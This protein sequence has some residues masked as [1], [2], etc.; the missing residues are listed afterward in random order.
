MLSDEQR[1]RFSRQILLAEVG[2]AGQLA[3][4]AG[5]AAVAGQ[6]PRADWALRHQLASEYAGRAGFSQLPPAVEQP[7]EALAPAHLIS[8]R[9][10]AEVLAASRLALAAMVAAVSDA[11]RARPLAP[12]VGAQ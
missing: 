12:N 5:S 1:R 8:Q 11:Q 7:L 3:I 6:G 9:G 10:P 4:L 2:E